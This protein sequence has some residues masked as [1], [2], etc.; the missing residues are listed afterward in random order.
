MSDSR[1]TRRRLLAGLGASTALL[2]LLPTL[3]ADAD[4]SESIKRLIV[5]CT[6]T[7][8]TGRYPGNWVPSG[9]ETDFT[10]SPIHTPLGGGTTV[11]G[12]AIDDLSEHLIIT[13]G[14]DMPAC[15]DS[16][17]V[18]GHPRGAGA[19]LTGTAVMEGDLFSG[20]GDDTAGWAGGKSIDQ[21][22]AEVI[23][24]Q[25]P[26]SSLELGVDNAQLN[27]HSVISYKD[28]AQPLPVDSDPYSVFDRLFGDL[29]NNNPEELQILR[30]RRLSIIDLA[31]DEISAVQ[32]KISK[33]DHVKM[34]EH[35]DAIRSIE[36]R[37]IAEIPTC[38]PPE[39]EQGLDPTADDLIAKIGRIQIEQMVAALRCDLTRVA[40]IM[41]GRA[42]Y[43]NKFGFL[44]GML[45]TDTMHELSHRLPTD[46]IAQDQLEII[47]NWYSQQFAYL[48]QL[49]KNT[50]EGDGTMLDNTVV[51]WCSEVSTPR[52]HSHNN[53]PYL[54]AGSAGGYFDT[55]RF[56]QYGSEP[57]NKLY[58]SIAQAMGLPDTS[59]G[60]PQYGTGPLDGL[61]VT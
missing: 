8:M 46:D 5:F 61:A 26:F 51:M 4:S 31:K 40:S 54:L 27:L 45:G 44:P 18:G 19:M 36:N 29:V 17:N 49:L 2:P 15:Y 28:A 48:L 11:N 60:D 41:W 33:A 32:G 52:D 23:G 55:G 39:L 14:I 9:S 34:E 21:R 10:L 12:V 16:P 59:F 50:P 20:G 1:F 38:T 43:S 13:Q 30:K 57:C 47:A 53:M 42:P 35:L 24:R 25:T 22:V 7:G 56:L 3:E 37:L 58:T 6:T